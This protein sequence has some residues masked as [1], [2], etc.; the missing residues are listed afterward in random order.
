MKRALVFL[1]LLA[2]FAVATFP[3]EALLNSVL[4]SA[5]QAR[6]L[7][8]SVTSAVPALP[9]GYR[10]SGL[11]VGKADYRLSLDS[12]YL[13]LF[14]G[15]STT[16]CGGHVR[17]DLG[18]SD[19]LVLDFDSINPAKCLSLGPL[20][21]GGT[22]AGSVDIEDGEGSLRLEAADGVFGGHLPVGALAGR[23]AGASGVTIGEW[24]FSKLNLEASLSQGRI[25]VDKGEAHAAEVEWLVTR[26]SLAPAPGGYEADIYFRARPGAASG[27][28]RAMIGL[29]PRASE[30]A[31]G[32][33]S[34]RV[35]GPLRKPRLLGL[36]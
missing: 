8:G 17:G 11:R 27:R 5:L 14:G 13:G 9:F 32:W 33:R 18:D 6:G 10:V 12:A 29:L 20:T 19:S 24:D 23:Q 1:A 25:T 7:E 22:F 31:D 26:G 36:K 16:G 2:L 35:S 30:N 34:Y 3:H 28:A 15:F 4:Q 21:L